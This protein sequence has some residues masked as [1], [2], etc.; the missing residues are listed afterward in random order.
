[1]PSY[2]RKLSTELVIMGQ[3]KS[4]WMEDWNAPDSYVCAECVEDEFLKDVIRQNV[5]QRQCDYC[6]RKTRAHSAAPVSIL[7]GPIG[8]AVFYHFNDP[9]RGGVPYDDGFVIESTDTGDVLNT[10][11]FGCHDRLFDDIANAFTNKEWVR[12]AGGHWASSHPNEAMNDSWSNFVNIV[13]HNV[14]FFF[15]HLPASNATCSQEYKPHQM[16]PAIGKLVKRL[17]LLK[18]LPAGTDLFRVRER[19]EDADWELNEKQMREPPSEKASAGRMN[20]VGISYLYLSYEKET[21]LAE[22]LKGPPCGAA[23]AHFVTKR[24]IN[25]LDLTNL[26][27]KPS[28]FDNASRSK[29][30]KI[31][32][33]ES[34][35][36][37][38]SKSV[39]K[40]GREHIEYVPSQV[41]SEYFALI[42]EPSPGK[43]LDGIAYRSSI[44]RNGRNLVLFP[45]ERGLIRQFDQVAPPHVWEQTLSDWAEFSSAVL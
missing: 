22:V 1:M 40:N 35:A 15:Q 45:T 38:I 32:F 26:P 20:P 3:E 28:I 33:L 27:G 16:L 23:I 14:R 10:L 37:E 21:A 18:K 5:S 30:E 42:F 25:I 29:R 17:K 24:D 11:E 2:N 13:K 43:N 41:V 44:R 19:H 34:F 8:N 31:L 7:M 39:E 6:E 36:E 4:K 9:T 12:A